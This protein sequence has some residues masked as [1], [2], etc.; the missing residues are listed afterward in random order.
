MDGS[1][2]FHTYPSSWAV[3]AQKPV[4]EN[5]ALSPLSPDLAL[6]SEN[7]ISDREAW[8]CGEKPTEPPPVWLSGEG[9]SPKVDALITQTVN[10]RLSGRSQLLRDTYEL[11][12]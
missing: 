7:A 11:L 3:V 12:G 5:Q 6:G 9:R 1:H 10:I 8:Q 2:G 4:P